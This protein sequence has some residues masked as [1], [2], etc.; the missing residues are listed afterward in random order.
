MRQKGA[1]EVLLVSTFVVLFC[2][3]VLTV[4][5][6]SYVLEA[7][8]VCWWALHVCLS[9]TFACLSVCLFVCLSVCLFV[10]CLCDIM[11]EVCLVFQLSI[12]I[13]CLL[14]FRRHLW[15]TTKGMNNGCILWKRKRTLPLSSLLTDEVANDSQGVSSV[16]NW[17]FCL[18]TLLPA[19]AVSFVQSVYCAC[20]CVFGIMFLFV[21]WFTRNDRLCYC[22]RTKRLLVCGV[23][24]PSENVG[25]RQ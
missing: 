6:K 8:L 10:C 13:F 14:F 25:A 2:D 9:G 18:S 21:C 15:H 4:V 24:R 23:V 11:S 19:F 5:F 7:S 22:V 12:R 17:T 3:I 16:W 20:V 1:S